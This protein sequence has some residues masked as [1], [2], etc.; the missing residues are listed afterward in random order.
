MKFLV[1]LTPA[2]M[3]GVASAVF[4]QTADLQTTY[5][6][7]PAEC[8]SPEAL[9]TISPGLIESRN[10]RCALSNERPAGTG[11]WVY[12]A[13]CTIEGQSVSGKMSMGVSMKPGPEYFS[14]SLPGSDDRWIDIHPCKP[15]GTE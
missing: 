1:G 12:A 11:L 8:S 5:A 15:A 9:I 4:A 6:Q 14:I 10:F 3:L 7:T 13:A 2:V